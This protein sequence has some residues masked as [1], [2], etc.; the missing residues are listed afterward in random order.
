MASLYSSPAFAALPTSA[1]LFAYDDDEGLQTGSPIRYPGS[2]VS[3]WAPERPYQ[4]PEPLIQEGDISEIARNLAVEM[5]EAVLEETDVP[6][7][8]YA[9]MADNP[10]PGPLPQD[11]PQDLWPIAPP[12]GEAAEQDQGWGAPAWCVSTTV[13]HLAQRLDMRHPRVILN[14]LRFVETYNELASP[15]Q[16]IYLPAFPESIYQYIVAHPGVAEPV[17]EFYEE[18]AEL[19]HL[20]NKYRCVCLDCEEH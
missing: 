19:R 6:P 14:F 16:K 2:P 5:A 11:L 20:L 12:G 4:S 18:V 8:I 9:R 10:N 15:D 1:R 13:P 3:P 17:P 7:F